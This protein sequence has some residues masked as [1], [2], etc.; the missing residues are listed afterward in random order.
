MIQLLY[1]Q[2][3]IEMFLNLN[4]NVHR[5]LVNRKE[6]VHNVLV[7]VDSNENKFIIY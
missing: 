2:Q 3:M 5:V 1:Y 4:D 6:N 7:V